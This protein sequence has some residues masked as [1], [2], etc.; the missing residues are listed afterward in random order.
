M[1]RLMMF[2]LLVAGSSTALCASPE[3][4][5][6]QF[7]SGDAPVSSVP[8][9]ADPLMMQESDAALAIS[10]KTFEALPVQE[11]CVIQGKIETIRMPEAGTNQ[12]YTITVSQGN[13][14]AKI[15]MWPEEV[16]S[17]LQPDS[18][19]KGATIQVSG[20]V[21]EYKGS[22]E[23]VC[24]EPERFFVIEKAQEKDRMSPQAAFA[25]ALSE[26]T[27]VDSLAFADIGTSPKIAGEVQESAPQ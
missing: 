10:L 13:A 18:V 9:S 20:I 16:V 21:Q 14:V 4:V 23:L 24:H 1:T 27:P 11:A 19:V 3:A 22:R 5:E 26:L 17:I 6:V 12:P 25:T 8:F 2:C 7:P 15:V